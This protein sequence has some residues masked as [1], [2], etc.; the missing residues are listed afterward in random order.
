MLRKKLQKQGVVLVVF[1]RTKEKQNKKAPVTCLSQ[2]QFKLRQDLVFYQHTTQASLY[3]DR[4]VNQ[5]WLC[6]YS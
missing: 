2:Y 3:T 5:C 6:L 1:K 4:K